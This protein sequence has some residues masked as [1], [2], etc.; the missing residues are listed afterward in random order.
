[1]TAEHSRP[2]GT[3]Q[4]RAARTRSRILAG[5]ARAVIVDRGQF[6][7]NDVLAD[8]RITKGAMY[9]HFPSKEA[10]LTAMITA[11]A[12]AV[13][14]CLAAA[15]GGDPALVVEAFLDC[16]AADPTVAAVCVLWSERDHHTAARAAT[17]APLRAALVAAVHTGREDANAGRIS[18]LVM[19]VLIAHTATPGNGFAEEDRRT[20][21]ALVTTALALPTGCTGADIGG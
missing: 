2:P 8:C 9:Y 14:T 7:I 3:L 18:D 21:S 16:A 19:A 6:S 20:L 12:G 5:T 1:M 15:D 13:R 4:L 11:A 10:A 17:G